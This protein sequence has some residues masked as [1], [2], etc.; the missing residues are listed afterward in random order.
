[1]S[2]RTSVKYS[3]I[4]PVYNA[5]KTLCRCVDSLLAESYSDMEIILVN[6]GSKDRSGEICEHYTA[7][8][9]NIRYISKE[10][11]GVSTARNAGL[12]AASGK[13]VLFVD[14]D[15]YVVSNYFSLLDRALNQEP[16]DLAQFSLLYDNS[17][18]NRKVVYAP[19]SAN[20]REELMP[21]IV[22]AICRKTINGP[23][24]KLYLREIIEANHIRF[25]EGA[26]VAEDRVFNIKYSMYIHS[27]AVS[28]QILYCVST[29]N[30]NSLTRG[31]Q[32]DLNAQFEI[33]RRFFSQALSEAPISAEEKNQYQRAY[34]FGDCRGI[35]HDA[36]LMHQDRV[37]WLK[38]Q[39][40]LGKTCAD[41]NRRHM[42]YPKT[43]YCTF[44]TLPVRL[45]LM[46]I[47][48]IIAWKL[49]R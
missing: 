3:V 10:N 15:D 48:D 34:N 38:R 30:E 13:Y 35:Y 46:P 14:S 18:E 19:V 25:P 7:V 27:Y 29:E 43:R 21:L 44:I 42:K 6:D 2:C 8:H 41:I 16:S 1:M 39:I 37:G 17:R 28:D 26:S 5:E 36:K 24:A 22:N 31:R 23:V 11:G 40:Q 49:T 12:D 33:N 9:P 4:I 47:I 32:K 45:Y 20:S